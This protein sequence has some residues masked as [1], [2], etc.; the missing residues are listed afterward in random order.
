MQPDDI[1]FPMQHKDL[2]TRVGNHWGDN[3]FIVL[4]GDDS[5]RR[6]RRNM[7][8]AT[9]QSLITRDGGELFDEKDWQP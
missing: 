7:T 9:L 1:P 3:T 4:M 6:M 5:V 8:P 2:I